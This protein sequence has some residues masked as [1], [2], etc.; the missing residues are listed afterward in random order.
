METLEDILKA[1]GSCKPFLKK[2]IID[3]EGHRFPFTKKGG[4]AYNKLTE[5]IYTVGNLTETDMND[6]VEALDEI[7]TNEYY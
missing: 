7:V 5:I 3:D 2:M 1:L 4:R 6:V